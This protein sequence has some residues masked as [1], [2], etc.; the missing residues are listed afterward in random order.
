MQ[1]H[2]SNFLD[3]GLTI[4]QPSVDEYLPRVVG[5]VEVSE[6]DEAV[7]A[8]AAAAVVAADLMKTVFAAQPIALIHTTTVI[9]HHEQSKALLCLRPSL[10]LAFS[11]PSK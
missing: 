4:A 9:F 7:A 10:A 8:A 3:I 6:E 2:E 1:T 5:A 11:F